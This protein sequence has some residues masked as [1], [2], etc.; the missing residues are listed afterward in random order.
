MTLVSDTSPI[1]YLTVIGLERFLPTLFGRMI[2]PGAVQ[3]ELK[4]VERLKFGKC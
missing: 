2:I 4:A 3:E 1:N